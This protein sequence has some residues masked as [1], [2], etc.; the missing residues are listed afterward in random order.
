MTHQDNLEFD[1]ARLEKAD[2]DEIKHEITRTRTAMDETIDELGRRFHP[3]RLLSDAV[4]AF[5]MRDSEIRRQ[6][7]DVSRDALDTVRRHPIPT[8]LVVGGI[9]WLLCEAALG[10]SVDF[11]GKVRAED[12]DPTGYSRHPREE[13]MFPSARHRSSGISEP[14]GGPAYG[15]RYG[16]HEGEEESERGVGRRM[17]GIASSAREKLRD[18]GQS[19]SETLHD[20]RERLRR[21]A[22]RIYGTF[23]ADGWRDRMSDAGHHAAER[24]RN[25][26]DRVRQRSAEA[27]EEHP[28]AV[29]AAALAAG[30][31]LGLL[32]PETRYENRRMGEESEELKR[33][34]RRTGRDLFERGQNVAKRTAD[35][36]YEEARRQGI[37]PSQ[38]ARTAADTAQ[39]VTERVREQAK[40][41]GERVEKVG[42][43]AGATARDEARREMQRGDDRGSPLSVGGGQRARA[44][45]KAGSPQQEEDKPGT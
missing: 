29:A 18:V 15:E 42:E 44:Q 40:D 25:A 13:I 5:R 3:R 37:T 27:V 36:A 43:T 6:I 45:L 34:A 31:V 22:R 12:D 41:L 1:G 26:A 8:A 17:R 11:K 16:E 39:S 32:I 4:E 7:S 19:V 24:A 35:A 2:A 21:R 20:A 38:V 33:R 14:Y 9:T 23:P 28:L 10:R 30:A